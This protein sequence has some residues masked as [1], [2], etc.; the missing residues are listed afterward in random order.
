MDNPGR[1]AA[2]LAAA[3]A[4]VAAVGVYAYWEDISFEVC[5]AIAPSLNKGEQRLSDDQGRRYTLLNKGDGQETALYDDHTAV[6]F[7]RDGDGNLV[8]EFGTASLLSAIASGY[9]AFHGFTPPGGYLDPA[10]MTYRIDGKLRPFEREK[11]EER[12]YA[13]RYWGGRFVST[14]N[15]GYDSEKSSKI[16]GKRSGFGHAGFRT[17]AS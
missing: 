12:Q 3:F 15:S 9:F 14:F 17:G 4:S 1:K 13:A 7:H 8:W 2:Y 10:T 11:E 6:T 5:S 16:V